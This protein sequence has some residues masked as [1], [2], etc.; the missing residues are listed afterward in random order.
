MVTHEVSLVIL[1]FIVL[2]L[3]DFL[4]LSTGGSIKAKLVL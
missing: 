1:I 2:H 4:L 3:K